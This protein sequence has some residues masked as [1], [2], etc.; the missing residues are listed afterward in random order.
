MMKNV[1]LTFMVAVQFFSAV[2]QSTVSAKELNVQETIIALFQSLA[3]RDFYKMKESCTGDFIVLE[4]GVIWN[5]DTLQEKINLSKAIPDF[6]RVNTIEFTD[7]RIKGKTAWVS[8]H[9]RADYIRNGKKSYVQWL[10]S[11]VLV[12]AG[13]K[14]KVQLLHSTVVKR[15]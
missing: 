7:T 14:W 5:L 11:A 6:N 10:E 12:K 15:G 3:D 13:R 9:N 8:Y 1:V 4:N 2:S